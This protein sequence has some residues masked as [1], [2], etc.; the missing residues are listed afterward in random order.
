LLRRSHPK[1]L[2][3]LVTDLEDGPASWQTTIDALREFAQGDN[4]LKLNALWD[5]SELVSRYSVHHMVTDAPGETS[6]G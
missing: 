3:D 2:S 1:R 6:M 4:D 5:V